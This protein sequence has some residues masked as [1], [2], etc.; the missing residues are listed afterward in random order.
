VRSQQQ[1][2][3]EEE[4]MAAPT[5]RLRFGQSGTLRAAVEPQHGGVQTTF[6]LAAAGLRPGEQALI[7]LVSPAGQ[8]IARQVCMADRDGAVGP[9]TWQPPA[10]GEY[11]L[12]VTVPARG[13]QAT[14]S[15]YVRERL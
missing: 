2:E 15:V 8:E 1:I 5:I 11:R 6:L 12:I 3:T 13:E 4:V 9:L 14:Q 7:S 10:S